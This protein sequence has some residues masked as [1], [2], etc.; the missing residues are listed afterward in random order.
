MFWYDGKLLDCDRLQLNISEPGLLYGATVFTTMRIYQQSLDHPL[1]SWQAHCDRLNSTLK[2]FSWQQPSWQDLRRGAELLLQYF[3]VLRMAIFPD[4]REWITGRSL[5]SELKQRQI[6]G[7]T[8]W[9][10]RE[11]IYRRNLAQ[12]KTGN[13]LSAYLARE[14]ALSLKAEEAILIDNKDNWL[15]TSTGNLWG[16]QKGRWYTPQLDLNILP[17]IARS[18]WLNFFQAHQIEVVENIWTPQFVAELESISYSNC[19]V[20]MIP[21]TRV[22]CGENQTNYAV[23]QLDTQLSYR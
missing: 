9:V 21:I 20:E 7:I 8:A 17:G 10:A 1:T 15:E 23:K 5:P 19:I 14:R 6:R 12:H 4:G 22:I 3:P 11:S 18:R 2:S 16:W 13:Y